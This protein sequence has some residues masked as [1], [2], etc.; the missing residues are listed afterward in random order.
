MEAVTGQLL[1]RN[2]HLLPILQGGDLL[3]EARKQNF[4]GRREGIPNNYYCKGDNMSKKDIDL[5]CSLNDLNDDN[6]GWLYAPIENGEVIRDKARYFKERN[7]VPLG[8]IEVSND[9]HIR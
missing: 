5:T 2:G 4:K 9:D 1:D 3:L 6:C 8:W 7:K